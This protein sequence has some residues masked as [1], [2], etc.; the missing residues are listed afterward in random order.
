MQL[1]QN[2]RNPLFISYQCPNCKAWN[3]FN[4][5]KYAVSLSVLSM[6]PQHVCGE[7]T[8][9]NK[10]SQ[11]DAAEV[12]LRKHNIILDKKSPSYDLDLLDKFNEL[13][14]FYKL[15]GSAD[16]QPKRYSEHNPYINMFE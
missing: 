7:C 2:P 14:N 1:I 3:C 9:N 5:S 8:R 6:T 12:I 15:L 16:E 4:F 10:F 13:V 11:I